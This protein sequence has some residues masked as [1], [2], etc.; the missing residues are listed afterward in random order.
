MHKM[1]QVCAPHPCHNPSCNPRMHCRQTLLHNGTHFLGR[2][3]HNMGEKNVVDTHDPRK[4]ERK[5][6][7]C[8][9]WG[10]S[11]HHTHATAPHATLVCIANKILLHNQTHS[12]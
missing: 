3:K 9:R 12:L 5:V 2:M 4:K 7:R 10:R 6:S 11:V 8:T 1:G